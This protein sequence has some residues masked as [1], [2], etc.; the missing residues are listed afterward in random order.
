MT[1]PRYILCTM[2]SD[3]NL[4]LMHT[5]ASSRNWRSKA[6][7]QPDAF[8]SSSS[9]THGKLKAATFTLTKALLEAI[10]CGLTYPALLKITRQIPCPSI[11]IHR[12][13]K[14]RN[15]FLFL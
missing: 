4:G 1:E 13:Q 2:Q 14:V 7:A 12:G 10:C 9:K 8:I 15:T 5:T 11:P 6:L 3:L